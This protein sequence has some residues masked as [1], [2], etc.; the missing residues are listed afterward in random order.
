MKI[1][2]FI[3][4][5]VA[6]SG[7]YPGSEFFPIPDPGSK[8]FPDLGSAS[9]SKNLSILNQKIVSK[10]DS[11]KYDPG[12][13]SRIRIPDPG[14]RIQIFIFYPS[15]IQGSKRHWIPDQ[16]LQHWYFAVIFERCHFKPSLSIVFLF[17]L[18][19]ENAGVMRCN[20][21]NS[22]V[23]SPSSSSSS[24]SSAWPSS[25]PSISPWAPYRSSQF[26]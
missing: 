4:F 1:N 23:I 6:N 18:F 5:A 15:Q 20:T 13:S 8:R 9:A 26:D 2:F 11:Q 10:L 24:P 21:S 16:D 19:V 14:S 12:C 3:Y 25:C 17:L 22:S 7:S